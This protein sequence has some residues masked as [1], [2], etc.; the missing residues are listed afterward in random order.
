MG[1]PKHRLSKARGRSRR[2]ATFKVSMPN[3]PPLGVN[4]PEASR[5][6]K[7]FCPEC[8]QP[9]EPHTVCPNCGFYRGRSL[10]VER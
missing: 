4:R 10:E 3:V 1:L 5:S 7:F 2:A 6:K 9:K 8:S